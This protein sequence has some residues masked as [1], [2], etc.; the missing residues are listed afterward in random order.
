[1]SVNLLLPQAVFFDLDG[2]LVDTAPDFLLAINK[3]RLE[4]G[5]ETLPMEQLRQVVSNGSASMIEASFAVSPE[6]KEFESLRQRLLDYYLEDIATHSELFPAMANLLHWLETEQIAWGIVTNKP[7]R[8]TEPLLQR[9]K[10]SERTASVVCPDHVANNKPDPEG[11]WL[12]AQQ[13]NAAP[14]QCIYVGDH[15]R[16]IQAGKNA[17]MRTITAL[18]GYLDGTDQP[19]EWNAD[20]MAESPAAILNWLQQ[21]H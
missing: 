16:D 20:F 3:L 12:A 14:N 6:S 15:L 5:L 9:L 8:Y 2:T 4:E 19:A 11:L 18:Y 17:G 1:M 21:T 10:L 13:A 7:W